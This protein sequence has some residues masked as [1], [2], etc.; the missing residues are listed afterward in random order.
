MS[1]EYP[2]ILALDT[3]TP[4]ASV[5]LTRGTRWDGEVLAEFSCTSRV[6]HSSRLLLMIEAVLREAGVERQMLGGI[7]VGLGPG[8]FTGLRIAMATAKGLVAASGL[9]LYGCSGLD[10]LAA[11]CQ[12]ERLVCAVLDARQ[13]EVYGALYRHDGRGDMQCSCRPQALS[14]QALA[15]MIDEPVLLV[16][17]A[18]PVYGALWRQQL[19]GLFQ[20]APAFLRAPSAAVLG[21]LA[22]EAHANGQTLDV[23]SATPL[24]VRASDAELNLGHPT[25]SMRPLR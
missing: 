15:G 4:V 10:C 25:G 16:G 14:P 20:A 2:V 21:L 24:Y 5:A 12:S 7:A 23:A 17:D 9:P 8:S 18:V 13:K 6:S 19:G 22:G 3:S 1:K 11:S